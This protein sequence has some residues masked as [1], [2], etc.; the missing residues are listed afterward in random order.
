MELKKIS[1]LGTVIELYSLTMVLS[2]VV[3]PKLVLEKW[4]HQEFRR[5]AYED[6]PASPS[7][8]WYSGG[9]VKT[10]LTAMNM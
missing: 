8:V 3:V 6:T 4:R 1:K 7:C 9:L 10:S 5:P 2:G